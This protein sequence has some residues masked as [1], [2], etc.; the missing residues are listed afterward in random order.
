MDEPEGNA[1]N[2][3]SY[4]GNL[5]NWAW[6]I[7]Q[8]GG[9]SFIHKGY[10]EYVGTGKGYFSVEAGKMVKKGVDSGE[11]IWHTVNSFEASR[12]DGIEF[13]DDIAD[14]AAEVGERIY[15]TRTS[16]N[17]KLDDSGFNDDG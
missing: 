2:Y 8:Y 9:Q 10:Y 13:N 6:R 3:G 17:A 7:N 14:A 4:R 15:T 12:Y 16:Y 1:S 5:Q 11:Y